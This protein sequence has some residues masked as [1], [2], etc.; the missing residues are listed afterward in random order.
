MPSNK[1]IKVFLKSKFS[2]QEWIF[3]FA[4]NIRY[5]SSLTSTRNLQL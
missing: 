1:K 4:K 2:Y 5:A 3:K